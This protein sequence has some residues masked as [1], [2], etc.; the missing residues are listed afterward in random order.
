VKLMQGESVRHAH[1]SIDGWNDA[2]H[3]DANEKLL[4]AGP[5][6]PGGLPAGSSHWEVTERVSDAPGASGLGCS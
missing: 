3:G 4:T 1:P 5:P 2:T 6:S